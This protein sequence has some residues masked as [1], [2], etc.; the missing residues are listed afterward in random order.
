MRATMLWAGLVGLGLLAMAGCN[1]PLEGEF[2]QLLGVGVA[3]ESDE[4]CVSGVCL[5]GVCASLTA[6]IPTANAGKNIVT[7]VGFGAQA[8][9]SASSDPQDKALTY[10]WRVLSAPAGSNAALVN[11]R[12]VDPTLAPDV[13]GVYD[14]E[15]VVS[16]GI[17]A[18]QPS[19]V[20]VIALGPDGTFPLGEIGDPCTVNEACKSGFCDANVCAP[21]FAPV[22]NAGASRQVPLNEPVDLD[23]SLSSDADGDDLSYEWTLLQTPSGSAAALNDATSETPAFTPEVDGLYV[24]QLVVNDGKVGSPPSTVAFL[25]TDLPQALRDT[26]EECDDNEQCISKYCFPDPAGG[27]SVCKINQAP[28]ADAGKNQLIDFGATTT[29]DGGESTDPEEGVPATFEWVV[30]EAPDGSNADVVGT[31]ATR[32]F[33]PDIPGLYTLRLV[34]TDSQ[35]LPSLP[36]TIAIAA[37]ELPSGNGEACTNDSDCMS[38]FCFVNV[39][40]TN[41]PPVAHAGFFDLGVPGFES[42]LDGTA[43]YDPEG[44]ALTYQWSL[45][46]GPNSSTAVLVDATTAEPA[47]VPDVAG[48]YTFQLVVNDGASNSAPSTVTLSVGLAGD[49]GEC[50]SDS[51]CDSAFCDPSTNLCQSNAPPVADAGQPQTVNV[52]ATVSLDGTGS[53]DDMSAPLT[54][55]WV[56]LGKPA[57]STAL[58]DDA[59]AAQPSF[60]ADVAGLYTLQLTVND[61]HQNSVPAF[62]SVVA[63]A[64]QP[65]PDGTDCTVD[66]DC[67]SAYCFNDACKTNELPI[68][69]AGLDQTVTVGEAA[70][71]DGSASSDPENAPLTYF[72][73]VVQAPPGST[74]AIVGSTME[75]AAFAPDVEGLYALRLVV[76]DGHNSSIPDLMLITAMADLGPGPVDFCEDITTDTTLFAANTYRVTCRLDVHQNA[77]LTIEPGTVVRFLT[78]TGIR[79]FDG[80]ALMAD[81]A[82]NPPIQLV[83]DSAGFPWEGVRILNGSNGPSTV[84]RNVVIEEGGEVWP[85]SRPGALVFQDVVG[86]EL[87]DITVHASDTVGLVLEGEARA[88]V[89]NN[90]TVSEATSYPLEVEMWRAGF[91]GQGTY[92]S[93]NPANDVIH[94]F[95]TSQIVGESMTLADHGLPYRIVNHVVVE[96]LSAA[97]PSQLTIED[98]VELEIVGNTYLDFRDHSGLLAVGTNIEVRGAIANEP[99][100][101]IRFVGATGSLINIAGATFRNGGFYAYEAGAIQFIDVVG[102]FIFENNTVR[103]CPYNGVAIDNSFPLVDVSGSTFRGNALYNNLQ[104]PLVI[105]AALAH[106]IGDGNTFTDSLGGQPNGEQSIWLR[107]FN[108]NDDEITTSV[109]W[110][111]HGIPYELEDWL[112]VTGSPGTPAVLTLAPGVEIDVTYSRGIR[113]LADGGLSAVGTA[114]DPITLRGGLGSSWD[115]LAFKDCS[116]DLVQLAYVDIFNAGDLNGVASPSASVVANNCGPGIQVDHV[117]IHG[118]S[119]HGFAFVDTELAPG[120]FIGNSVADTANSYIYFDLNSLINLPDI[121]PYDPALS[122]NFSEGSNIAV[123]RVEVYSGSRTVSRNVTLPDLGIPYYFTHR[124][125]VSTT[126]FQTAVLTVRPSVQMLFIGGNSFVGLFVGN[127]GGLDMQGAPG[128][129]ILLGKVGSSDPWTGIRVNSDAD[130]FNMTVRHVRLIQA[131][132][133]DAFP[134][135]GGSGIR[136]AASVALKGAYGGVFENISTQ[137]P[138]GSYGI[139]FQGTLVCPSVMTA[140]NFIPPNGAG[141]QCGTNAG[142]VGG[143]DCCVAAGL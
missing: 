3:C 80:G 78:S 97:Q 65:G 138:S 94:V 2:T 64:P 103:N 61:G 135:A 70:A 98:G 113:V 121:A 38:S 95:N 83:A 133:T 88:G 1:D 101:Y 33:T 55:V 84:L 104:A 21:N 123:K 23:G 42:T 69:I 9:G 28:T 99:W 73:Y 67:N 48:A 85:V 39:C 74:A 76:D 117:A 105:P 40:E 56:L 16:N 136:E 63:Q 100:R 108:P 127:F 125:E 24:L 119:G 128:E 126:G 29:V 66:A 132:L 45:L 44:E 102:P 91:I 134:N 116:G 90:V 124:L 71:L 19:T 59:S 26:D 25:A 35:A 72:W 122:G 4:Q 11:D 13:S 43:S 110:A 107:T 112:A 5:D 10:Q 139:Y 137:A 52:A 57:T 142:T 89:W 81:S 17:H 141:S 47:F 92:A 60:V 51:D 129:E 120:S 36:A 79:V 68:A 109:T 41:D 140:L 15:L 30:N 34:V 8:D 87:E 6:A 53:S 131:G 75:T 32:T 86:F 82:N 46:M 58:L 14:I 111:D 18:S 50:L 12:E 93:I 96:G 106:L 27:V 22:A 31:G 114:T 130:Y 118:G 77:T 49:G 37:F 62:V 20:A 143:P 54:Y 7:F 115:G